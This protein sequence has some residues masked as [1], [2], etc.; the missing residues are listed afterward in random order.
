MGQI[1]TLPRREKYYKNNFL[2]SKKIHFN[3]F[4]YLLIEVTV[5]KHTKLDKKKSSIN[6]YLYESL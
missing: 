1:L 5:T 4:I 6:L 3:I 2:S